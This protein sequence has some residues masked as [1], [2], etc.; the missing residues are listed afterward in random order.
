MALKLA[1]ALLVVVAAVGLGRLASRPFR[2]RV[3]TLEAFQRLARRLDPFIVIKQMPL[4]SALPEASR[5]LGLI[6]PAVTQLVGNLGHPDADVGE[7]WSAMLERV[8]GLWDEDRALLRDFGRVL[9]RTDA[10]AQR[11]ELQA[12]QA[13][14]SRLIEE[15]RRK[16]AQDGRLYPALVGALGVMVV[17]LML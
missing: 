12:V 13:E 3:L 14:L 2:M 7:L 6:A 17:I 5:G 10:L 9:G 4:A 1:A 11:S 16:E 8:P 15:A